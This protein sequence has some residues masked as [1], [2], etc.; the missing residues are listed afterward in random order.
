MKSKYKYDEIMIV[1]NQIVTG[2]EKEIQNYSYQKHILSAYEIVYQIEDSTIIFIGLKTK[3]SM[4]DFINRNQRQ[5][6]YEPELTELYHVMMEELTYNA[7]FSFNLTKFKKKF[8]VFYNFIIYLRYYEIRENIIEEKYNN[9]PSIKSNLHNVNLLLPVLEIEKRNDDWEG[10]PYNFIIYKLSDNGDTGYAICNTTSPTPVQYA[11]K[12]EEDLEMCAKEFYAFVYLKSQLIREN[13]HKGIHCNEVFMKIMMNKIEEAKKSNWE[14]VKKNITR[15]S[16]LAGELKFFII[17]MKIKEL[18]KLYSIEKDI[19]N[20]I[21]EENIHNYE[22]H[23]FDI[24]DYKWK[25]EELC[26]NYANEIYKKQTVIHQYKP[27]F[28][29]T[30]RGQLSYDIFVCGKNIAIEY[31]GKQHFEP[32]DFFGGEEHYQAQIKRDKL[33][34]E[35]SEKNGI[36]LVYINYWEDI[37]KEL[38]EER[39]KE[40]I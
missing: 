35:L 2:F 40:I 38:I 18:S 14:N 37:T 17:N 9:Y 11:N 21:E 25:S 29:R 19:L 10:V 26:Y 4:L 15:N 8:D 34:K 13:T 24:S 7:L 32:V 27:L 6:E 23:T 28:L 22:Q 1:F 30:E 20:N 33:K 12:R 39:I 3:D 31:Q 16:L 36:K 5:R